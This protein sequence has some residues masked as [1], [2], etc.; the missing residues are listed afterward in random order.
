MQYLLDT[1]AIID[2]LQSKLPMENQRLIN[3]I[4]DDIS[5]V[6][7]ISKMETLGFNFPSKKEQ[8]IMETFIFYS[9][10]LD[11]DESIVNQ[12]ITI[13]KSRKIKLPDA[14]IAAT[15]IVHNLTLIT[16][17][18]ADFEGIKGLNLMNPYDL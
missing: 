10:I 12:T 16:R 3:S 4:V 13:R 11:I 6:S 2:Y 9:K 14:I 17:N 8:T 5:M 7:V 15:A 1:N 18:T